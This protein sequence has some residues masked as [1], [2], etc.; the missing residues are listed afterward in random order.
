MMSDDASL[1]SREE[2]QPKSQPD[3]SLDGRLHNSNRFLD[4]PENIQLVINNEP[5][6]IIAIGILIWFLT[7]LFIIELYIQF[8]TNGI[9]I[10][11]YIFIS[12]SLRAIQDGVNKHRETDTQKDTLG[13]V[14]YD[15]LESIRK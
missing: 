2:E 4:A 12:W 8:P 5:V 14:L 11:L 3:K 10:V 6:W 9:V 15:K 1:P 7:L 13:G